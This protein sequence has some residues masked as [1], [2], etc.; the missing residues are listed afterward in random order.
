MAKKK[1]VD[2]TQSEQ[3]VQP[4]YSRLEQALRDAIT[5]GRLPSG[6]V[7]HEA[8]LARLIGAS[9]AP[10][11]QA[12][13]PLE[14]EGLVLRIEGR[15]YRVGTA[16]SPPDGFEFTAEV[17]D[18][19]EPMRKH[20]AWEVIYEEVERAVIQRSVFGPARVNE[21]ELARHFNVGRTVARDVITRL[22]G[23]GMVGKDE[24]QR[25][26]LVPLTSQR[27]AD[28]YEVR[29]HLEPVAL[30]HAI[31]D[32]PPGKVQAMADRLAAALKA[33]PDVTS[34]EMDRLEQDLHV[35]ALSW[36]KNR[37]LLDILRRTRSSLTLSKHILGNELELPENDPF[38]EEHLHVLDAIAEGKPGTAAEA[39]R[40]HIRS[41][42]PKVVQRLELFQENFEPQ[43]VDYLT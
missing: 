20:F 10:V 9:R 36:C 14:E 21:L 31:D 5:S 43:E 11:R 16:D 37:E 41:S 22:E 4:L 3:L 32:I 25:W 35:D 17:L 7:V 23:L 6:A 24:R 8:P 27:L 39:I 15:G 1:P 2:R 29:E 30:R 18:L 28:I 33:Y 40:R 13:A 26:S 34:A 12:L 19:D 42:C 38:L